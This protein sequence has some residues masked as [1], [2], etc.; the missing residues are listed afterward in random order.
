MTYIDFRG[1]FLV[2]L[3]GLE[4]VQQ[5]IMH[6]WN[7][8]GTELYPYFYFHITQNQTVFMCLILDLTDNMLFE[9]DNTWLVSFNNKSKT[10]YK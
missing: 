8:Q 3:S 2:V 5:K 10:S 6:T 7:N 9:P 4:K 1:F